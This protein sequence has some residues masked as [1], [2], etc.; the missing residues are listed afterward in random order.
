QLAAQRPA[1]QRLDVLQLVAEA[2]LAR[3]NLVV[4]QGV[5]HEGVVGVWAVADGDEACCGGR[6]HVPVLGS[7]WGSLVHSIIRRPPLGT[8]TRWVTVS[9]SLR[10]VAVGGSGALTA[11]KATLATQP[12]ES[13]NPSV[14]Q[15]ARCSPSNSRKTTSATSSLTGAC[16]GEKVAGHFAP[17]DL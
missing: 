10:C 14:P 13:Q 9:F 5:E 17:R 15:A 1:I 16:L 6:G 3:V 11:T 12:N 7:G 8:T 2:E 4:G